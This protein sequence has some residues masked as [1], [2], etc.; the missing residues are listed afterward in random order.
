MDK[1]ALNKKIQL[2]SVVVPVFNECKTLEK[3]IKDLFGVLNTIDRPYEVYIIESNS[4]D[5]SREL[6]NRMKNEYD[7]ELILED[8]PKGKGFAVRSGLNLIS[9]DVFT[10]FDVDGEYDPIDLLDLIKPIESGKTSFVLGSRHSD[11]WALRRL[12]NQS[13]R[14]FLMNVAHLL[15]TKLINSLF[16]S[17][18]KDPFTMYKVIRTSVFKNIY[19]RSN[20][21]DLDWELVCLALRL[22]SKPIELPVNYVS[23]NFDEGKKIRFF[24]DPVTWMFALFRFKFMPIN[25]KS[26]FN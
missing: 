1:F 26:R 4:T 10:I 5:G 16:K 18:L 22:G 25:Q 2:L 23:R 8:K 17:K 9:G 14:T 12:K 3:C 19:L 24:Y 21:F 13:L 20:R 7:F 6:I 11:S 15:F